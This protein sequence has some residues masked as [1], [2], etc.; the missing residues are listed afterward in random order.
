MLLQLPER[1][2]MILVAVGAAIVQWEF[3]KLGNE[4]EPPG[5]G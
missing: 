3:S 2:W 5:D 1:Y 4:D